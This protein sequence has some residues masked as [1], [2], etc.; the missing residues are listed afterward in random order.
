MRVILPL[1]EGVSQEYRKKMIFLGSFTVNLSWREEYCGLFR[2]R[3]DNVTYYFIDNEMYFKRPTIYGH[4]DDGERFAFFSLAVLYAMP[5]LKFFPDITHSSDWHTALIPTYLKTVFANDERYKNIKTVY[6][7]HNIEYQG[8]FGLDTIDDVFGINKK[9]IPDLEYDGILNLSKAAILFSD[10]FTTVSLSYA[11]EI[12]GV[13]ASHGLNTA[14]V[15]NQHKMRGIINGLDYDFYNPK[16]DKYVY[17]NYNKDSYKLKHKNKLAL[18][19]EVGL[20]LNDNVPILCMVCRLVKHKGLDL[21][22]GIFEKV[23][24]KDVQFLIVGDGEQR[25]IDFFKQMQQKYPNKVRA[26]VGMYSNIWAR[27][28]YAGADILLMPSLNEPCGL[29]QMVASR[30]GT[31]PIVREIGGLKDT[32]KDFGCEGGGNGYTFANYNESDLFYSVERA[33]NDFNNKAQWEQKIKIV[34]NMDFSW[35]KSSIQYIKMYKEL[36]K[37]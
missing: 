14:I 7:I 31:I 12:K 20:P 34:M 9:Y 30:Y 10:I 28:L 36:A 27:K 24:N 2:Y 18:Q 19:T 37:K 21:V 6:T 13:L 8:K 1:Y 35:K 25:Y 3:K 22:E 11:E 4:Y 23:I 33:I 15:K 32:V 5:F 17:K 26:Y 16:T 29:S